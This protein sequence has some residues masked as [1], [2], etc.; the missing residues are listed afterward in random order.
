MIQENL[1]PLLIADIP[2]SDSY[3]ELALESAPY[4]S[5]ELNLNI[6]CQY[7]WHDRE[8]SYS[9]GP[10]RVPAFEEIFAE[11]LKRIR[12]EA[13]SVLGHEAQISSISAPSCFND[14]VRQAIKHSAADTLNHF[15]YDQWLIST[16][17]Y[18]ALYWFKL[19]QCEGP[20]RV[21]EGGANLPSEQRYVIFVNMNFDYL[22]LVLI[23]ASAICDEEYNGRGTLETVSRVRI[24]NMGTK[25]LYTV[26]RI[27]ESDPVRQHSNANPKFV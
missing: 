14:S 8:E 15:D 5:P 25:R 21:I 13:T 16:P 3:R 24:R 10:D 19:H 7:W 2:A 18:G 9:Y 4:R 1:E 27:Q 22:E 23:M 17:E 6:I 20:G 26:A 11:N 12:D